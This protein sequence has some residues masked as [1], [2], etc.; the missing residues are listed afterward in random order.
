MRG[1]LSET[2]WGLAMGVMGNLLTPLVQTTARRAYASRGPAFVAIKRFGESY[3]L[4][5]L[6]LFVLLVASGVAM[7]AEPN[8]RIWALFG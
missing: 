8:E 7:W 5:H 2:V 1:W 4:R 6:A 3:Q